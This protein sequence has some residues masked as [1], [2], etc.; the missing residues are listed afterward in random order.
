M[1]HSFKILL[2]KNKYLNFIQ[3]FTT[4][5][6][7]F[8]RK[9]VLIENMAWDSENV[10]CVAEKHDAAKNIA[11]FLSSGR[12]IRTIKG[13]GPYIYNFLFEGTYYIIF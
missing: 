6:Y 8:A 11:K 10:L 1:Q 9:K 3:P 12:P 5:Y 7:Q 2:F 13:K 4:T